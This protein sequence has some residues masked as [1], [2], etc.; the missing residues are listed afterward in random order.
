MSA[1][2]TVTSTIDLVIRYGQGS[3]MVV[4]D[5]HTKRRASIGYRYDLN[6]DDRLR[7]AVQCWVEKHGALMSD[8][9]WVIGSVAPSEWVALAVWKEDD[10]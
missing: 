3:R 10:R 5:R 9:S 8:V 6:D 1:D 2:M 4:T 7:D